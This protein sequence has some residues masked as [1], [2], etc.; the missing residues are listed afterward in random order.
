MIYLPR[1]GALAVL[2]LVLVGL[3]LWLQRGGHVPST[4]QTVHG[5]EDRAAQDEDFAAD[6]AL[7]AGEESI[8][9]EPGLQEPDDL[10]G[11][12]SAAHMGVLVPASVRVSLVQ[13]GSGA[14]VPGVRVR[15]ASPAE[16]PWA[17]ASTRKLQRFMEAQGWGSSREQ[18]GSPH[19]DWGAGAPRSDEQGLCHL[20][21]L[22]GVPFTLLVEDP[23]RRGV[24]VE[25]EQ[26]ALLAGEERAVTIELHPGADFAFHGRVLSA[27]TGQPIAGAE[28]YTLSDEWRAEP[29]V[30]LAPAQ[31]RRA[32]ENMQ[33]VTHSD[34]DGRFSLEGR[35]WKLR[36]LLEDE[37]ALV[38]AEHFGPAVF[39]VTR[40]NA[41][42]ET[43]A[44]LSLQAAA[45]LSGRVTSEHG[46]GRVELRTTLAS[47]SSGQHLPSAERALWSAAWELDGS[48]LLPGLAPGVAFNVRLRLDSGEVHSPS[49]LITLEPGERR[50]MDWNLSSE[51]RVRG[52]VIDEHGEVVVGVPVA[53]IAVDDARAKTLGPG[54]IH[55]FGAPPEFAARCETDA[56]G[57]FELDGLSPGL[58]AVGVAIIDYPPNLEVSATG[59]LVEVPEGA[60]VVEAR[61][62]VFR[63]LSIRGVVLGPDEQPLIGAGV[64][65]STI[66][67]HGFADDRVDAQGRFELGPLAPGLHEVRAWYLDGL[68][69]FAPQEVEAGASDLVMRGE[70]AGG[71]FGRA[72]QANGEA[73]QRVRVRLTAP[74]TL[75]SLTLQAPGGRF[76][77]SPLRPGTY[78][79][80]FSSPSM[81]ALALT[82][83]VIAGERTELADLHLEPAGELLLEVGTWPGLVRATLRGGGAEYPVDLWPGQATRLSL[84][85]GSYELE[86]PA[87]VGEVGGRTQAL[88]IRAGEQCSVELH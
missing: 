82:A 35:S 36:A 58:W 48:Y 76:D 19:F 64:Y 39:G 27:A 21:W 42:P 43:A 77:L 12:D 60:S 45:E 46:L 25:S 1:K 24:W 67:G 6:L 3:A 49:E 30:P 40:A 34:E 33:L 85:P 44:V 29:V 80:I 28:V 50:V 37:R 84:P 75:D 38:V 23:E 61:I 41:R 13:G 15:F 7:A 68:V 79:L 14:P 83:Q 69:F 54:V 56:E 70:L 62:S 2:V 51:A 81:D 5:V 72:F 20:T 16:Q 78:D 26:P 9:R 55:M 53:A 88:T 59:T 65:S 22:A 47:L 74:G 73:T 52:V 11:S 18:A 4:L 8:S 66:D 32:D 10:R 71:L 87:E 86:L 17:P 31:E 63:D 57:R